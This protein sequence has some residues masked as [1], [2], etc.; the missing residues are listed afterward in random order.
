MPDAASALPP[1]LAGQIKGWLV[2]DGEFLMGPRYVQLLEGIDRTGTIR[3]GCRTT[4]MSYRTC[5]TRIRRMERAL[6][7]PLV[8]TRRGGAVRGRAEL[9]PEARRL[10]RLYRAWRDR[11]ERASARAFARAL[12]RPQA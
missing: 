3:A 1:G 4:R 9:T 8:V 2:L 10:I 6:G 5:L 11:V 7:T 12:A